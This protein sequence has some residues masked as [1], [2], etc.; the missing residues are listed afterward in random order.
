[1]RQPFKE[2]PFELYHFLSLKFSLD[3]AFELLLIR[4]FSE[5]RLCNS[6]EHGIIYGTDYILRNCGKF[7]TVQYCEIP[8]RFL[9]KEFHISSNE[10]SSLKKL[11]KSTKEMVYAEEFCKGSCIRNSV[12]LQMSSVLNCLKN[13]IILKI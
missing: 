11:K 4:V 5:V 2:I 10:N 1:M 7:F 8:Y 3:S 9:Y 6:A 12:Y 13:K